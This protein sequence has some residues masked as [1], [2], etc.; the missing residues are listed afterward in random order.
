MKCGDGSDVCSYMV[1]GYPLN[2]NLTCQSSSACFKSQFSC[3]ADVCSLTCD[4]DYAC[5]LLELDGP[6][7]WVAEVGV[8]LTG[9]ADAL[10]G[11]SPK[12][13][14]LSCVGT[15]TCWGSEWFCP[16]GQSCT[17]T[18][19]GNRA[20]VKVAL[21]GPGLWSV[22]C[23]ESG[24]RRMTTTPQKAVCNGVTGASPAVVNGKSELHCFMVDYVDKKGNILGNRI[25]KRCVDQNDPRQTISALPDQ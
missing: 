14:A 12:N 17:A 6:G 22:D 4:D 21:L 5:R 20:C 9:A 8:H 24:G 1:G 3:R 11:V 18:C 10:K 25:L 15:W 16:S 23:Q 19:N 7:M 13:N 2:N